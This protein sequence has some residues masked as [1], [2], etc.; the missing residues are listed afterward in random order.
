MGKMGRVERS[1]CWCSDFGPECSRGAFWVW[2]EVK[3][4]GVGGAFGVWVE[5]G[6][7]CAGGAFWVW[8][9]EHLA[10]DVLVLFL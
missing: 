10:V 5:E 4:R 8:V 6:Q 2:V 7:G 9:E 1:D 3:R